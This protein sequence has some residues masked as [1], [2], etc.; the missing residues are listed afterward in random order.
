M[1]GTEEAAAEAAVTKLSQALGTVCD[2]ITQASVRGSDGISK[3]VLGVVNDMVAGMASSGFTVT[4][5]MWGSLLRQQFEESRRQ[6]AME[7]SPCITG[8]ASAT[9]GSADT[10]D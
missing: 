3:G 9:Q 6:A 10:H 7:L 5:T 2:A 8:P 4:F 1:V